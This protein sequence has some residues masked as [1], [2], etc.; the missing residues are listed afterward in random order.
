[1]EPTYNEL[2]LKTIPSLWQLDKHN[3][4][5]NKIQ[6]LNA[7]S[8][9]YDHPEWV[10]ANRGDA[11]QYCKLLVKTDISGTEKQ[12]QSFANNV[13]IALQLRHPELFELITVNM[14]DQGRQIPKARLKQVSEKFKTL[15]SSRSK[16]KEIIER[17]ITI[18]IPDGIA[19]SAIF[20]IT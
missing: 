19:P 16:F 8:Y 4:P 12:V 6:F 17:T 13:Q 10:K 20:L 5:T 7:M 9:L 14:G 11:K 2:E 3:K 1:M 15:F 18:T